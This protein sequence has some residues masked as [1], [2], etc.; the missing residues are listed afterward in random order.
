MHTLIQWEVADLYDPSMKTLRIS[1][2]M[3]TLVTA[4][5]HFLYAFGRSALVGTAFFIMG[6]IYIVGA[7]MILWGKPLFY[8]LTLV[9]TIVIILIYLYAILQP[10]PPFTERVLRPN[11][12]P[13]VCKMVE[14]VLVAVLGL[15]YGKS[16]P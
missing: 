8:K 3:L 15:M 10:I 2:L 13:I 7:V 16:R 9:Y 14:V 12:L 1:A 5:I 6:V 4:A 11:T